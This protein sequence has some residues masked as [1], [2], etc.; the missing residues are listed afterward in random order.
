MNL[1]QVMQAFVQS[2]VAAKA[3]ESQNCKLYGTKRDPNDGVLFLFAEGELAVK[4]NKLLEET[5][6]EEFCDDDVEKVT[7][8]QTEDGKP[9]IK[10]NGETL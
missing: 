2:V 1:G 10:F 4:I 3:T 7:V 6:P 5:Y 8:T 9:I